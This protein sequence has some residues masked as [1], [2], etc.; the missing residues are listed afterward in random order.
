[1]ALYCVAGLASVVTG[2]GCSISGPGFLFASWP[3]A[4]GVRT[5]VVATMTPTINATIRKRNFIS[6]IVLLPL[7]WVHSHGQLTGL[8]FRGPTPRAGGALDKPQGHVKGWCD[9]RTAPLAW[10][11][12]SLER[13]RSRNPRRRFAEAPLTAAA[14]ASC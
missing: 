9:C 4:E 5:A 11:A 10:Q 14:A 3:M 2:G 7:Q 12:Q 13:N 6:M 8:W 1:M